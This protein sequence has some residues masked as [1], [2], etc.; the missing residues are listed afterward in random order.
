M[1]QAGVVHE[2]DDGLVIGDPNFDFASELL[3]HA[4]FPSNFNLFRSKGFFVKIPFN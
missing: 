2:S 1:S 4:N 3:A